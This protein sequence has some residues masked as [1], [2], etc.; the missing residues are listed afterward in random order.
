M[1]PQLDRSFE[2]GLNWSHEHLLHSDI[3]LHNVQTVSSENEYANVAVVY[4]ILLSTGLVV[5]G[6]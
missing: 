1:L 2:W 3:Y 6:R 5:K 4:K